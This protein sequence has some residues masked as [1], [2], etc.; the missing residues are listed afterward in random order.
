MEFKGSGR[1]SALSNAWK[2]GATLLIS[3]CSLR[4]EATAGSLAVDGVV[5]LVVF[6]LAFV[7]RL[8]FFSFIA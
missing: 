3:Y 1:C 2:I 8:S 5:L 4:L 7:F 6:R